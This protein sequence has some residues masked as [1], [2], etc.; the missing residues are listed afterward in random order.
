VAQVQDKPIRE[1]L[2]QLVTQMWQSLKSRS[3]IARVLT[4]EIISHPVRG[5][6][7]AKYVIAPGN[8]VLAGYFKA[9]VDRGELR[10]IRPEPASRCLVGMLWVFW[11]NQKLL[12][13]SASQTF[14]DREVVGTIGEI[15]LDGTAQH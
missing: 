5:S 7:F 15:F 9:H 4:R 8:K 10:T 6:L 1:G 14:S 3:Q 13:G 12:K 2:P 11:F